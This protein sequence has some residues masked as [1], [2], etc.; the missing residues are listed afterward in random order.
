MIT[1]INVRTAKRR[2]VENSAVQERELRGGVGVVL[3]L[4][5]GDAVL[6]V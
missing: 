1:E 6:R 4:L 5:F 3:T 2:I